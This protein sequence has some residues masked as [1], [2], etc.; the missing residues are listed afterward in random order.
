ML[1]VAAE[2][3]LELFRA[4]IKGAYLIPNILEGSSPNVP[5]WIV[6]SLSGMF[7]EI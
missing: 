1:N 3:G 5:T 6:K 4:E 7:V 2:Y